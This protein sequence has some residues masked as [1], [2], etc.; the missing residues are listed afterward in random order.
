MDFSQGDTA[1]TSV[2]TLT[3]GSPPTIKTPTV[4]SANNTLRWDV[5]A[6]YLMAHRFIVY[7][8]F[9]GDYVAYRGTLT[10]PAH[11][12]DYGE[13]IQLGYFVCPA[14]Q[15][16]TRYSVSELDGNTAFKGTGFSQTTFSE[17]GVG[18]N[19]FLGADGSA[20]NHAKF[21]FD[22]DYLPTGS[23]AVTGLDY[24]SETSVHGETVFRSQFQLWL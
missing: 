12:L 7:G 15:L 22:V 10:T 23:P 3:A 24:Q 11:R 18:F 20:G 8:E 5:D 4:N 9:L 19:Y 16:T 2:S 17:I 14:F 21:S 6:T 1:V 13:L